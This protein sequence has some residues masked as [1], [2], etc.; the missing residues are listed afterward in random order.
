M[1]VVTTV[2]CACARSRVRIEIDRCAQDADRTRLIVEL[3]PARAARRNEGF[4]ARRGAREVVRQAAAQL[5]ASGDGEAQDIFRVV[6][7]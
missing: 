2:E 4:K 7:Q 6:I 1:Q 5:A 3:D